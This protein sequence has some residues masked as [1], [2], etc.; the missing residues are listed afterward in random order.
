M[1]AK[2]RRFSLNRNDLGSIGRG[3]LIA[4]GGALVVYLLEVLPQIDFGDEYTPIIVA[5][6]SI[7]LNSARKWI[8]S[9]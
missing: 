8:N 3:A 9:R 4:S 5:L 6:A 1:A 7:G 2:N